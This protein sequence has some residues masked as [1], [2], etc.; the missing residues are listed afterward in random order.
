M[1]LKNSSTQLL[2][3]FLFDHNT[4]K[5]FK[6]TEMSNSKRR[7]ENPKDWFFSGYFRANTLGFTHIDLFHLNR[8]YLSI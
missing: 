8:G 6:I 3:K 5:F 7:N 4:I 2:Q 1:N